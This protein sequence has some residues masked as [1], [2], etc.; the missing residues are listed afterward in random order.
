MDSE[1]WE[2]QWGGALAGQW[3]AG[4]MVSEQV[5]GK[6][7]GGGWSKR[8]VLVWVLQ[9]NRTNR[10]YTRTY[11]KILWWMIIEYRSHHIILQWI[12]SSRSLKIHSQLESQDCWWCSSSP[13][14][15]LKAQ[16]E[17]SQAGE[18]P[19][20][21]REDQLF[22]SLPAFKEL[23]EAHPLGRAISF[24]QSTH[25]MLISSKK[26]LIDTPRIMLDQMSGIPMAQSS[27]YIKLTVIHGMPEIEIWEVEHLLVLKKQRHMSWI[28]VLSSGTVQ[29]DR[30]DGISI[31]MMLI[32][33][34]GF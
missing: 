26:A 24:T 22:C 21:S 32:Q 20:Y 8:G 12:G 18:L 16:T 14:S 23:N 30:G 6:K 9:R 2:G 28:F 5:R 29:S 27:W 19:S 3:G 10:R 31:Q 15:R 1:R 11:H 25:S 13:S 34:Q 17:G 4:V 7:G 33:D